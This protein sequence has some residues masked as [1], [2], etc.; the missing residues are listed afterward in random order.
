M[1]EA[2]IVNQRLRPMADTFLLTNNTLVSH[3]TRVAMF[4]VS[5]WSATS[6]SC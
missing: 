2:A 3:A 4:V 5:C 6:E 1:S